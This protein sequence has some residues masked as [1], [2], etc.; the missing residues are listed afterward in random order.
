M[1]YVTI[2]IATCAAGQP[3]YAVTLVEP[4]GEETPPTILSEADVNSGLWN[5]QTIVDRVSGVDRIGRDAD[6]YSSIGKTFHDWLRP[7]G[8]VRERWIELNNVALQPHIFIETDIEVFGRL[9]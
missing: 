8:S 9:P 6:V 4:G 5:A 7:P 2:R 3:G 1:T